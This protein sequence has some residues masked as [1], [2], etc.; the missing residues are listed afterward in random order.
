MLPLMI[1]ELVETDEGRRLIEEVIVP[2]V[3]AE[4]SFAPTT[5]LAAPEQIERIV[6]GLCEARYS[7][8]DTPDLAASVYT[9]T[10]DEVMRGEPWGFDDEDFDDLAK[11]VAVPLRCVILAE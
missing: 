10:F 8:T 5:Y 2:D 7:G 3:Y 4:L 11:A 6:G 1:V 9:G